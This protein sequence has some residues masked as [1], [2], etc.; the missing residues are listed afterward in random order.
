MPGPLDA[1]SHDQRPDVV[2]PH[3]YVFEVDANAEH[4]VEPTPI[5][6]MGRFYHEAVAVDPA[7]G[8]VYLTEDRDD[9][10]L[11]RYRPEVVTGGLE[12]PSRIA[13]GDLAKGGVLEALR[14]VK[15]P[16]ALTQNWTEGG[17]KMAPGA[18]HAVDWVRIEDP[19]PTIDME[20]DPGD[21]LHDP[22]Q[23]GPRTA[24]GSTRAQG[25]RLGAAQFARCEGITFHRSSL[26]FCATSGGKAH[27]GQV[28]RLQPA[29]GLL[30]L[31]LEPD[32][33]SML[34][35]P[36]NIVAAP[37][38]DLLVCEDGRE[39]NYVV[40]ITPTGGLY[41]LARNAYNRSEFAGACF[42]ADRSTLFVNMQD[43]G[44]T[45]AVWGPWRTRRP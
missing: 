24:P 34:D 27:A 16:A 5:R 37:T 20:R 4:L 23:R 39:D 22:L 19:D 21:I 2:V 26:Y 42:S 41:H 18:P 1:S 44:V 15:R 14:L 8:F 17:N 33:R 43:P 32:Q 25:F 13:V 28:W 40:G 11:Y 30:T 3:G 6:A 45:F 10:L 35:G 36:D 7:T 29:A 38:G 9:G 31:L 12:S